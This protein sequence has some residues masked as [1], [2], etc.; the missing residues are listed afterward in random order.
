[1]VEV[2]VY[3]PSYGMSGCTHVVAVGD[4]VEWELAVVET[5][6]P[7]HLL[8][9]VDTKARPSEEPAPAVNYFP[10]LLRSGKFE[11][12]WNPARPVGDHV[13][14]RGVLA[15]DDSDLPE[16]G[17]PLAQGTI[18]QLFWAL[19]LLRQRP[20]G[21]WEP[22]PGIGLIEVDSTEVPPAPNGFTAY[23]PAA[24]VDV[25]DGQWR[26]VG[27]IAMLRCD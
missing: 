3:V 19:D 2:P 5:Y 4:S 8:H 24:D 12:W 15:I 14:F 21:P 10:T 18:S 13:A 16:Q 11:A 23:F 26:H 17:R 9:T 6:L 22:I 27:W 1:M 20:D 25:N 7:P